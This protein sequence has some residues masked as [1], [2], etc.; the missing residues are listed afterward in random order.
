MA[1][2]LEM[3]SGFSK[4]INSTKQP[5]GSGTAVLAVMKDNTS[6]L[7]PHF[8]LK[9]FN[10]SWNYIKWGSRYYFVD[11]IVLL[12][13]SHAEYVCRTDVLATY[14]TAI[15][16]STQY[17]LR[18][19]SDYNLNIMDSFYPVENVLTE[20]KSDP[21]QDPGWTRDI[22]SGTFVIGVIG[23][24]ASPNGGAVTYYAIGSGGMTAITNYLLDEVNFQNVQD[25][26][27][28]MLKCIFNPLDYIVSCMWFPFSIGT[29]TNQSIYVGW[30]E[31]TG[32]QC[33][34][35]TDPIYTRNLSFTVPKH[36]QAARGN[37]LNLQP[38]ARYI[39]DAG[40]WGIIP[41]NN[42]NFT[43][44]TDCGFVMNIDLYTGSG[45]LSMVCNSVLAYDED[46][47]AQIG[48]PIQLGQ[49]T[50]NQGAVSGIGS[51]VGQAVSGLLT[52]G[53][54]AILG[55]TLTSISS[56]L[57]LSQS[58]VSSIGSNGTIAFNTLFALVGRF[59]LVADESI[60]KNGR[61]LCS[62][63]TIS[64]LSGYIQVHN[65]DVDTIGTASEK[66]QVMSFLEGGF[67][68]E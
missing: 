15:G 36:P 63:R 66:E 21:T 1:I 5:S 34:K 8:I 44:E 23:K 59:L 62:P 39:L 18:S 49:N 6:V 7:S 29:L 19:A 35:I 48:V 40:P 43:G 16:S 20:I 68:Y 42:I 24:N 46:Y 32:V 55:G 33:M 56:V 65:P 60:S 14:K 27:T 11:D 22:D 61:P 50:L 47:V 52:G 13:N 51:G 25:V 12:S 17:V 64:A 31:I 4:E 37:Y 57:E 54:G 41:I 2:T 58:S 9:E 3:F 45:R 53:H 67:Y 26:T 30:W 10:T 28:D 38:Y